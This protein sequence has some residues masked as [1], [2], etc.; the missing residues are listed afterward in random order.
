MT[1]NFTSAL[2]EIFLLKRS[3]CAREYIDESGQRWQEMQD[4]CAKCDNGEI[5]KVKI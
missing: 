5:K 3:E 4:N 2:R 1:P